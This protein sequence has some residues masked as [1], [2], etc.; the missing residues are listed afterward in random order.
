MFIFDEAIYAP[1]WVKKLI[2]AETNDR[3]RIH[4][5]AAFA[6]VRMYGEVDVKRFPNLRDK[7]EMAR[8]MFKGFGYVD[9][10]VY[11]REYTGSE[12]ARDYGFPAVGAQFAQ[13]FKILWKELN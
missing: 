1:E 3:V 10:R 9:N 2:E 8:K 4:Q 11:E 13:T 6:V 12:L 5:V 7:T